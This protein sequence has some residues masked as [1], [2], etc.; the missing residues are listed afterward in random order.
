ML[1]K[2]LSKQKAV[3]NMAN[4]NTFCLVDTKTRKTLLV[5]SSARK[6][7]KA[8]L[9]GYRVD[10]WS[11]NILVD[12]IY[13]KSIE[14]INKYVRMEKEYIAKKQEIATLRNMRKRERKKVLGGVS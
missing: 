14:N 10:V 2:E 6:C 13:H 12:V 7:K 5:T 9:K 1:K 8:F 4:Y 11:K 3:L